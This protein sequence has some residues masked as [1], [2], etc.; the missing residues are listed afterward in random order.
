MLKLYK[1]LKRRKVLKNL[2]VYGAGAFVIIQVADIVFER[3]LLP[4]WTVTFV[5]ILALLGFPIALFLSWT[6]DLKREAETDDES[7]SGGVGWDKGSR[8]ILLP[9][10]G[11]LTIVGGA[12]WVL[13]SLGDI[14]T[15]SHPASSKSSIYGSRPFPFNKSI[16]WGS[17]FSFKYLSCHESGIF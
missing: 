5:I 12:F 9:I 15:G 10:T 7:A 1:E 2:G 11:F 14:S 16:G 17:F 13:Y 8:K 3:L 6:Y 4:D